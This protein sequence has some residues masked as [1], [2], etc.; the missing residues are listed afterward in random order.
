MTTRKQSKSQYASATQQPSIVHLLPP[1]LFS[2]SLVPKNDFPII[3]PFFFQVHRKNINFFNMQKK[4]K[5]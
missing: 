4:R 5:C 2:F 1:F 3:T